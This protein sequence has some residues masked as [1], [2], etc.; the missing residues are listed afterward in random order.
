MRRRT[1]V[2]GQARVGSKGTQPRELRG[3]RDAG[4][5]TMVR[6][7]SHGQI[8]RGPERSRTMEPLFDKDHMDLPASPAGSGQ[9]GL[10]GEGKP[11]SLQGLRQ[12][13]KQNPQDNS[14]ALTC[15]LA[16]R[17]RLSLGE[18]KRMMKEFQAAETNDEGGLNRKEFDQVMCRIF[19]VKSVD[20]KVAARAYA[21]ADLR[22]TV[23]IEPFL[24]WY[25]QN[26]FTQVNSMN[27]EK[28]SVESEAEVYKLAQEFNISV[29]ALDKVKKEFDRYDT[30]KSG[31][32]DYEEF[33]NMFVSLL[34]AKSAADVNQERLKRF[35]KEIDANADGGVCFKEFTLWYM[36]YFDVDGDDLG[37][38]ALESFYDSFNPRAQ[39]RSMETRYATK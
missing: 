30:N 17:Y 32:I 35:W 33:Q 36:K 10:F 28:E 27:G 39:R 29:S 38:A 20:D 8:M 22:H 26:M 13:S 3:L 12:N 5:L 37:G 7:Q 31:E 6:S 4:A 25:L 1:D 2:L 9:N 24:N 14:D 16:L 11:F 23:N 18:T 34:K 19:E 21:A 15:K